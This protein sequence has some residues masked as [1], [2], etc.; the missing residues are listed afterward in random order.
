MLDVLALLLEW[1]PLCTFALL[2]SQRVDIDV[3]LP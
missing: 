2:L 3:Q 1:S